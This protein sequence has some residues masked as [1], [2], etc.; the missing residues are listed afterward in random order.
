MENYLDLFND[1]EAAI[2]FCHRL[3][4]LLCVNPGDDVVK[5][6]MAIIPN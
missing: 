1:S 4:E 3:I 2:S 6:T 5:G